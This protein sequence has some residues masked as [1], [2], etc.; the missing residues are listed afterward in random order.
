MEYQQEVIEQTM[1]DGEICPFCKKSNL[2]IRR[3][4][5][6]LQIK[7]NHC[8]RHTASY[9]DIDCLTDIWNI[10]CNGTIKREI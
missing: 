9:S 10:F 4:D 7:C 1:L 6:G 2:E 5:A 8:K 3:S